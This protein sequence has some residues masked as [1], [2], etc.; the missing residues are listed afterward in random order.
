MK[1]NSFLHPICG[2]DICCGNLVLKGY[3]LNAYKVIK[4]ENEFQNEY[5]FNKKNIH[6]LVGRGT[7]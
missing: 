6:T 1:E 7:S 4:S 2:A 3:F 5:F